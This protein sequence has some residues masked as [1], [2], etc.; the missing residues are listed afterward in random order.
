[1]RFNGVQFLLDFPDDSL[2]LLL[3]RKLEQ[4]LSLVQFLVETEEVLN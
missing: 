2:I 4:N 3:Q 1:M